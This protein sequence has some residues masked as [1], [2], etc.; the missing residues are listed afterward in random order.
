MPR[1]PRFHL[2]GVPVHLTQRG[3]NR[4]ACFHSSTDYHAYQQYLGE[5]SRRYGVAVHAWV[6]M[7]NHVHLLAT[8]AGTDGLP[9]M[10]QWLGARYVRDI[11]QTYRRTGSLWEGRYKAC[12]VDTERYFLTCMRYIELNPVRAAMVVSPEEY[13]WSSYRCNALGHGDG[14]T[15]AHP[16]YSALGKDREQRQ[17]AYKALFNGYVDA[18]LFEEVRIATHSGTPL[19]GKDFREQVEATLGKRVGRRGRGRPPRS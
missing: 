8:P 6:F 13:R 16:I 17:C 2:P 11:N 15:R 5:A 12:L 4:A 10:M 9:R 19:G 7:T 18:E 1:K 14:I 3:N